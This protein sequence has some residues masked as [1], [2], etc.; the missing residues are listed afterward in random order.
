MAL[1]L[2]NLAPDVIFSIFAF[3]DIAS[4]ISASETCRYLHNLAFD[5]SVWLDLLDNLRR[6]SILDRTV[7][8]EML[9]VVEMIGI[10]RRL[11]DG[12]QTWSSSE[13]DLDPIAE[14]SKTITLH[15]P[16]RSDLETPAFDWVKLLP[17]GCYVLLGNLDTLE[18]WNVVHDTL[19]WRHTSCLEHSAVVGFSAEETN[20]ESVIVIICLRTEVLNGSIH[21]IEM[22]NV[23]LRTG[24]HTHLLVARAPDSEAIHPFYE[25]VICGTLAAVRF[26]SGCMIINWKSKS[27]AIVHGH[28]SHSKFTLI[29]QHLIVLDPSI[30][31]ESQ[32]HLISNDSI[33]AYLLPEIPKVHTFHAINTGQSFQNMEIHASPIHD[34]EYR[35]WI[36][37]LNYAV[38]EGGLLSYQLSIPIN[39]EPRWRLRSQ[40]VLEGTQVVSY[41]GHVLSYEPF[42]GGWT[43]ISPGSSVANPR[44]QLFRDPDFVELAIYSGAMTCPTVESTVVI[45]YYR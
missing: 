33:G 7:N 12:P 14:A 41:S 16:I 35:L 42:R 24:T 10:V 44:L 6:R 38:N 29:P 25:P 9:S 28:D 22:V 8:L 37:G 1:I 45:Q 27:F 34:T 17:S 19:V 21:F 20:T 26:D 32:I 3:C 43:I 23:D 39:G 5:K 40:T 2:S 31:G 30:N 36:W 13:H 18:C 11:I 15:P 4:V